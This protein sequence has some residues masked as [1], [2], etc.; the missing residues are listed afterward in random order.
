MG[1][2][3]DWLGERFT[4][5]W[6][7]PDFLKLWA[8]E[9]ISLLGSQITLLALPLTA[10]LALHA[11][12][13]QMGLLSAVQMSPFLLVG[14]FAGVWVDR[15][16]RR[17]VLIAADIGR[18]VLLLVIPA[19]ARLGMLHMEELYL[20]AFLVGTLTVFFDVAYQSFLPTLVG[21][22]SLVEGNSKLE[23]SESG[24]RVA[25]PSL[26]GTLVG[27]V[28]APLA[29]AADALS[30]LVSA[31][32]LGWIHNS[33]AEPTAAEP[34]QGLWRQIGEGLGFV[35]GQPLLR[36]ITATTTTGNLFQSMVTA[37]FVLY[38]TRNL[39]IGPGLLGLI[40]GGGNIGFLLGAFFVGHIAAR[41]GVGTTLA[42]AVLLMGLAVLLIPL[43]SGP[44][45]AVVAVLI[46]ARAVLGFGSTL[47][48]VNQ[49]SLR[50]AITPDRLQGRMNASVRFMTWGVMPLGS[51]A[52]GALGTVLGLRATLLIAALGGLLAVLWLWFSPVRTLK[53]QPVPVEAEDMATSAHT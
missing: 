50:Q 16:R 47:Y 44:L 2:K 20:I 41:I 14:L 40:Y 45:F 29:I 24:A 13:V 30:F 7:H 46:A 53:E 22:E 52:G 25:G 48:N 6:R 4:G 37:I 36:A 43:A 9:T 12:A 33:E 5:L 17:P 38:A 10:V 42:G 31:L 15:L 18:F 8:G 21:R 51:L 1:R 23:V 32:F 34:G 35:L 39:G 11:N 26:A 49:V 28:T 19:A 27:L 3:E